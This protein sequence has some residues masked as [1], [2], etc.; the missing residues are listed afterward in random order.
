VLKGFEYHEGEYFVT[1][2]GRDQG[3]RA[4]IESTQSL[5]RLVAEELDVPPAAR[6]GAELS[7]I[8]ARPRDQEVG[9]TGFVE[10][11]DDVLQ[12]LDA[13]ESADEQ[14]IGAGTGGGRG[15]VLRRGV[16]QEGG[17][18]RH[19]LAEAE[20]GVLVSAE[21]AQ[22][23]EGVDMACLRARRLPARQSCGGRL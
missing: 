3:S 18:H 22:R 23:D 1:D 12:P 8:R 4:V 2:R 14:E 15:D 6:E 21:P 19:G 17:H 13:L 10:G 11:G 20:L 16:G 9:R 5:R 7:F